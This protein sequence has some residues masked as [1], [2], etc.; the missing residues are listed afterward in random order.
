MLVSNLTY[1]S[2]FSSIEWHRSMDLPLDVPL[3]QKQ[4]SNGKCNVNHVP[5]TIISRGSKTALERTVIGKGNSLAD[6]AL[7]AKPTTNECAI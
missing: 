1:L 2:L 4:G 3:L 6:T 7:E 5:N